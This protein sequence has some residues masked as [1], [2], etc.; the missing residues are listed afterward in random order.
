MTSADLLRRLRR[1][2]RK[3][4]WE[5]V[6]REASGS[7]LVGRLNGRATVVPCHGGDMKNPTY[8]GILKQLGLTRQDM[9]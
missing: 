8:W 9:E 4:G 5:M 3:R 2:A 1:L 6:E 7:H